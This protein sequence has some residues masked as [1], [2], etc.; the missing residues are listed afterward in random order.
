[1]DQSN[2]IEL[3]NITKN[4]PGVIAL[5][6]VSFGIRR[7]EVHILVGQN[8]AGKSS[9]VKLLTG[10]YF[11]DN[12]EILY[13]GKPYAPKS[14]LDAFQNGIRVVHQEFNLLPY[15]SVA[16]NIYFE[17]LPV[18]NGIVDF[19]K[20]YHDTE[21][22]LTKVGLDISPRTRVETLG[23]A[24][25]QLIEIAKALINENKVLIMDE[26]TATLTSKEIDI[27]FKIIHK[28]KRDGVTII[29]ISHR[30]Q[31]IYEIGDRVTVLRNGEYV[32]TNL[33]TELAINDL[34]KLMVGKDIGMAYPFDKTVQIGEEI[35]RVENLKY[36]GSKHAVSLSLHRGEILGISGLVGSGRTETVRA[37]FGADKKETGKIFIKDNEVEI[38][39]PKD[40]VQNGLS[41]LTEDRKAQGLILNM[42][43][44]FNITIADQDKVSKNGLIQQSKELVY[45][46]KFADDVGIVT[47][48]V[49]QLVRNL[50]GGNQQKV[51]LAKWLFKNAEILIF[52]EP[53]RG[54][55]VGARYDIYLLLWKLASLGK[56][57]I[58]VSS[59]L[60][61]LVGISHR[62]LVFSDGKIT[63]ELERKDFNQEKILSYAYEEYLH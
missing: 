17:K 15:L 54:I 62:I 19:P 52:D 26:P 27:L 56:G 38:N 13:E 55:D 53:T 33:L 23:V 34:V 51:V 12:G 43:V 47:P 48:S 40:A 8:G 58:V 42:N 9:L 63:G 3:I 36:K 10:I 30:L 1:M 16:E 37:I 29:Y 57:I 60:D 22:V 41:L 44:S 49:L 18:K 25:M 35:F 50:S 45:T 32:T 14:T 11:P 4:F 24:Q 7:G 39:S 5:N 21:K 6:N 20:L 2:I 28:L 46:K 61:E 59:D 31:E